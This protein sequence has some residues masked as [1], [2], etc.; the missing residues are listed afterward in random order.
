MDRKDNGKEDRGKEDRGIG[1]GMV[2]GMG[3]RMRDEG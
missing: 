3:R 1:G 2:D